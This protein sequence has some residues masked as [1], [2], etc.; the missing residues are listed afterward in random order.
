[1]YIY[2]AVKWFSDYWKFINFNQY[3]LF[4]LVYFGSHSIPIQKLFAVN[5]LFYFTLFCWFFDNKSARTSQVNFLFACYTVSMCIKCQRSKTWNLWSVAWCYRR[6]N[7]V[8]QAG[9]SRKPIFSFLFSTG[10]PFPL[11]LLLLSLPC[12]KTKNHRRTLRKRYSEAAALLMMLLLGS[13]WKCF[14]VLVSAE[15][16]SPPLFSL[17]SYVSL[18]KFC[19][20]PSLCFVCHK[21]LSCVFS[22]FFFF[23]FSF[24]FELKV[25]KLIFL[26]T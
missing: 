8:F 20:F 9:N 18:F 10:C 14:R 7:L 25:L 19:Q 4:S 11:F 13:V 22:L 15:I 3:G 12:W 16:G 6:N 21:T 17:N 2:T 24:I 26:K 1:M 23:M 5:L